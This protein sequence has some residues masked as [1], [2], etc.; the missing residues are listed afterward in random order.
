MDRPRFLSVPVVAGLLLVACQTITEELPTPSQP[1]NVAGGPDQNIVVV[2]LILPSP[3]APTPAPPPAGG[4]GGGGEAPSTPT[5][6]TSPGCSLPR[7]PGNGENCPRLSP[8]FLKQVEA[9]IDELVRTEPGLFNMNK[10]V[11]CATCYEVR[12]WTRYTQ[13]MA[14]IVTRNGICAHY[15]GEELAVKNSNSFNDQY[16]ILTSSGAIRRELGS[17]RSTCSPAWF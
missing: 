13:R 10:T 15:D 9:G 8:S 6:P 16:D 3:T 7:G 12:D 5:P 2:P 11:G 1:T 4:G 17:Y 14:Q